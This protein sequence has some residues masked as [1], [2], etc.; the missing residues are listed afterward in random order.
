MKSQEALFQLL[1][2]KSSTV[3]AELELLDRVDDG[4][5]IAALYRIIDDGM[6]N[7]SELEHFISKRTLSR[8]KG[9][10]KLNS[11]ESD[12]MARVARLS[13]FAVEVFGS[14]EK[15]YKWMRTP[16][17]ALRNNLPLNLLKTDLGARLVETILGRID[18]GIYS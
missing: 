10:K 2:R 11:E 5:P 13:G 15:A 7:E 8:R 17:K 12:L 14:K 18:H 1:T 9:E 6:L 16:N 3:E 4:L